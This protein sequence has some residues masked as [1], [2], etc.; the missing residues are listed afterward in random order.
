[1]TAQQKYHAEQAEAY[2]FALLMMRLGVKFS[3]AWLAVEVEP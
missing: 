1:M 2:E 3:F